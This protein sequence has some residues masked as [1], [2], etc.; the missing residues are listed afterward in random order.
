MKCIIL[1]IQERTAAKRENRS[2]CKP[3]SITSWN[4]FSICFSNIQTSSRKTSS[5]SFAV[6]W[7]SFKT[8]TVQTQ[9]LQKQQT[10]QTQTQTLRPRPSR[11]RPSD[12]NP[13][14]PEPPE[15][16]TPDPNRQTQTLQS[17]YQFRID[18]IEFGCRLRKSVTYFINYAKRSLGVDGQRARPSEHGM[19]FTNM[20]YW[21][22]ILAYTWMS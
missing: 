19:T 4:L 11:T 8:E 6:Q 13:P 15:P 21:S 20:I 5:G 16:D 2:S 10:L 18:E 12:S 3:H 22:D 14:D 17:S 1:L 9:T 7:S